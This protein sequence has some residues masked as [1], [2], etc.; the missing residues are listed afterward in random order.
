MRPHT[1]AAPEPFV[2]DAAADDRTDAQATRA[3]PAVSGAKKVVATLGVLAVLVIIGIAYYFWRQHALQAPPP[4]V[5]TTAP[6]APAAPIEPVVRNPIEPQPSANAELP[7]LADSDQALHDSLAPLFSP[8][9]LGKFFYLDGMIR[10]FVATVDNLP[11]QTVSPRIKPVRPVPGSFLVASHDGT[12]TAATDN[13]AR[14]AP[15]VQLVDG[16]DT[17]KLVAIYQRFYPLFQ[18]AYVELGYPNGYF[19]DRLVEVID[20]LLATPEPKGPVALTQPKVAYQFA[21]P[22]LEALPAGQK[23]LLRIGPANA[24]KVK[25][26]LSEVRAQIART[27]PGT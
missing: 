22:A 27:R 19:N 11:R 21:D 1:E 10:R 4:P 14:Y 3:P 7:P 17:G 9:A 16:V 6:S 2:G 25:A 5:P 20:V 8:D 26:K 24:A 23:I 12:L 13:A 15:Y 18:Q